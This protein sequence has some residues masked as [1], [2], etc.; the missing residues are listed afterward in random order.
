[1]IVLAF[2]YLFKIVAGIETFITPEDL[3]EIM[4]TVLN[5]DFNPFFLLYHEL[6]S[7]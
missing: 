5:K 2:R 1:M 4:K 3:L 7:Y 6:N